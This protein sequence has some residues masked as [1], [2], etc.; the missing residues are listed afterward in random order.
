MTDRISN[1]PDCVSYSHGYP[2][3]T[4]E[5][6]A[7]IPERLQVFISSLDPSPKEC[8]IFHGSR[9]GPY[10]PLRWD[11]SYSGSIAIIEQYAEAW[12]QIQEATP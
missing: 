12:R 6:K 10:A 11:L 9:A 5:L 7:E 4:W 1:D 8:M 3:D 2:G